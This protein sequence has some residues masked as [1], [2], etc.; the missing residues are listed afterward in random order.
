MNQLTQ[1]LDMDEAEIAAALGVTTRT[2]RAWTAGVR[3]PIERNRAAL[4]TLVAKA[5]REHSAAT[6]RWSATRDRALCA[7]KLGLMTAAQQADHAAWI[8]EMNRQFTPARVEQALAP[9]LF[10]LLDAA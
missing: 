10:T 8:A 3:R 6:H 7:A 9:N 1:A 4:H 5:H 2:V